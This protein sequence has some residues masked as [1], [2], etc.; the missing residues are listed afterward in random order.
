M[1]MSVEGDGPA[2]QGGVLQGDVIVSLD[3]DRV[4]QLDELQSALQANRAGRTVP[5]QIVRSGAL[6]EL[7]VTVGRK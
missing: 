7:Q 1:V 2:G 4:Q 6:H 3:G 5:V